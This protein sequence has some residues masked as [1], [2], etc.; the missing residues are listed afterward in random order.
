MSPPRRR[1][2]TWLATR[3]D[4]EM[5]KLAPDLR[6]FLVELKISSRILCFS[7]GIDGR[8]RNQVDAVLLGRG[9]PKP[10]VDALAAYARKQLA[11]EAEHRASEERTAARLWMCTACGLTRP[12]REWSTRYDFVQNPYIGGC[13]CGVSVSPG[14]SVMGTITGAGLPAFQLV[15]GPAPPVPTAAS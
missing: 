15:E 4:I 14:A 7:A 3:P 13:P 8:K 10:V 9:A 6:S 12:R 11:A 1:L 2:A 5:V